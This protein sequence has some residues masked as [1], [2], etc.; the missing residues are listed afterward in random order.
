MLCPTSWSQLEL[1]SL[2]F[3]NPNWYL[4]L[5]EIRQKGAEPSTSETALFNKFPSHF[6]ISQDRGQGSES[7]GTEG[8]LTLKLLT[9]Q[10]LSHPR[11]L[12]TD[13]SYSK[14]KMHIWE[15]AL[16]IDQHT[17]SGTG[18]SRTWSLFYSSDE[19]PH[20]Q[21]IKMGKA[22]NLT[23]EKKRAVFSPKC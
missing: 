12:S 9:G 7:R 4:S 17:S 5:K 15:P 16:F 18:S 14:P 23:R 1:F 11:N 2:C 3:L 10:D 13:F 20:S 22:K 6:S 21:Q 19:K 8:T